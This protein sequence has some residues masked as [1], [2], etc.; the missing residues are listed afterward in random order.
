MSYLAVAGF[1]CF[2]A[3]L[4]MVINTD[5]MVGERV[6]MQD[7]ADVT[8]LSAASW[9]ARGLNLVSFVNVLNSKLISTAVLLNALA[10]ALPVV[11]AVGE[12]QAGIFQGCT[13]VP[14]VGAFC[15]VMAAVVR[16]QL[17]VLRPLERAVRA[18]AR[19]LSQCSGKKALWNTMKTLN[20]V[21]GGIQKSF[22]GIGLA[23]GR[24]IAIANGASEGFAMNGQLSL[25]GLVLPLK[26]SDFREFCPKIMQGG[27]GYEL[28]GY[29]C[30]QG[31]LKLGRERIA[32]TLLLPFINL[33]A[34]PIFKG[35]V[36]NHNQ[37]IGCKNEPGES[38]KVKVQLRDLAECKEYDAQARWVLTWS[39]TRPLD[40]GSLTVTD[41]VPWKPQDKNVGDAVE[42]KDVPDAGAAGAINVIPD[43]LDAAGGG[44]GKARAA[45]LNDLETELVGE[46]LEISCR[47]DEYPIYLPP[48]SWDA[49]R[50]GELADYCPLFRQCKKISE[51]GEFTW[52]S[53]EHV[54]RGEKNV[55]G[56]FIRVNRRTI[57][58]KEK[59]DPTRYTYIVETVSMVSAGEKEMTQKEH[60]EYLEKHGKGVNTEGTK[61][62]RGCEKPKPWVLDTGKSQQERDKFQNR[63]RFIA[64]VYKNTDENPPFWNVFFDQTPERV[65][66]YGQAQVYNYLSED[67]FTQDWRVRL[68]QASLLEDFVKK[69]PGLGALSSGPLDA[70]NNH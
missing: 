57:E 26:E 55:G 51:F 16:V 25:Q 56:Y 58:P 14:F 38:N 54:R 7:T 31:P 67:T 17:S 13:G 22:M 18:A 65:I 40:D 50:P 29:Q 34:G 12:V 66:A 41:F 21:A 39:K 37:Q 9:T 69:I 10:D 45:A 46:G 70:V 42:G 36:A 60:K 59:G 28:E 15:A 52:Y 20:G 64:L 44:G 48:G 27:P 63:L 23:E 24:D 19:N 47:A 11:I 3:L 43:I 5:N 61:S 53:G 2:V 32:N 30:S 6:H 1:V 4:A 49:N 68:E 33:G 62:S 8:A 35:M